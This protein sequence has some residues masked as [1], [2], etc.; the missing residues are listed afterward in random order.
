MM[1]QYLVWC[2]EY[3]GSREDA[4]QFAALNHED[5]AEVWAEWFDARGDYIIIGGDTLTVMV[6][7]VNESTSRAFQVSGETIARYHAKE[8]IDEL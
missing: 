2:P 8:I 5:A 3:D 4:R 7:N 1:E 6:S